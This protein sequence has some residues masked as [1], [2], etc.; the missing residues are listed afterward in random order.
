M[1]AIFGMGKTSLDARVPRPSLS[2]A[3]ASFPT[4]KEPAHEEQAPS[5]GPR[6]ALD[7]FGPFSDKKLRA[8]HGVAGDD[9][10]G[11]VRAAVAVVAACRLA[12]R[13]ALG[14]KG[15]ARLPARPE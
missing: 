11:A 14:L 5:L 15:D 12:G 1:A 9:G 10:A 8:V 3:Q 6:Q 2:I 13:A 4:K 7:P